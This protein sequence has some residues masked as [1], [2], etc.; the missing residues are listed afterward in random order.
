MTTRA[1]VSGGRIGGEAMRG[2]VYHVL[3]RQWAF[4]IER[5]GGSALILLGSW[6]HA[7]WTSLFWLR[8]HE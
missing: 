8:N 6:K 5:H 7:Y 1:S 3:H 4:I 2:R